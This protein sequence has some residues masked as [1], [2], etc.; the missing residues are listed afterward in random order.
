MTSQ[1]PLIS[2]VREQAGPWTW[3]KITSSLLK[4]PLAAQPKRLE[5][6][7]YTV[8]AHTPATF[9]GRVRAACAERAVASVRSREHAAVVVQG[10]SKEN[11]P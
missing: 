8:D 2:P 3:I 4:V 6:V 5:M 7:L 1:R 11:Q 10:F 9:I